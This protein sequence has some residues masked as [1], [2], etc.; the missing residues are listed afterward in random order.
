MKKLA[1][2]MIVLAA[3]ALSACATAP[4]TGR[5]QF[6][7]MSADEELRHGLTASRKVLSSEPIERGTA[8]A[9]RIVQI[10]FRIASATER[11]DIQW[12]FHVIDNPELNAFAVPGGNVFV[13]TG[14]IEFIGDSDE[15]LATV[16]GHEIA[17]II[18]RHGAERIS[19]QRTVAIKGALLGVAVGIASAASG[20]D[21]RVGSDVQSAVHSLADLGILLPYSRAQ[22][23]EADH[24]GAILMAK[25]GYDPRASVTLWRRMAAESARGGRRIALLSTHPLD[26]TRIAALEQVM[27]EAL[28]HYRSGEGATT[29]PPPIAPTKSSAQNK[30][31]GFVP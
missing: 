25:A 3:L 1:M 24:I 6:I 30:S 10:G 4:Y 2:V 14:L 7:T 17:H 8:R 12:G 9:N 21:P 27:P 5:S 31:S 22:E 26:E 20:G 15:E 16:I 11:P 18:A 23:I 28:T 19:Q 29:P 13:F